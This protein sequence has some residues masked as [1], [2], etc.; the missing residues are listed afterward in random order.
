MQ[1][2]QLFRIATGLLG[3][4]MI[5]CWS[6][7]WFDARDAENFYANPDL[8]MLILSYVFLV[9]ASLSLNAAIYD[10]RK[11][12]NYRS[13]LIVAFIMNFLPYFRSLYIRFFAG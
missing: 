8:P 5:V 9:C 6:L 2:R 13:P 1:K 12:I 7:V 3:V 11:D 10:F 4:A